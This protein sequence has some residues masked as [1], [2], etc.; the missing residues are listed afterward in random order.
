[1]R[2]IIQSLK[3]DPIYFLAN[4]VLFIV[5]LLAMN[6]VFWAPMLAHLRRRDQDVRDA[7]LKVEETERE[8]ETLRAEYS[9]RILKEESE[10]RNYIQTSVKEAMTQREKL[11]SEARSEAD[12]LIRRGTIEIENERVSS[13]DSMRDK[14]VNLAST[15]VS[16]AVGGA[17]SPD[18]LR[19]S[20]EQKL[21][22]N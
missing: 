9:T 21:I 18:Q 15:V 17:L 11:I 20:L 12:A 13:L 1:M 8:L 7:Y 2:D 4:L 22:K 14:M 5:L 19:S 16:K 6:A 3:F 10:A